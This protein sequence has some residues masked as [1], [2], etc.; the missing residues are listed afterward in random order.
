MRSLAER[1]AL[2]ER[3]RPPT[4]SDAPHVHGSLSD[5]EGRSGPAA[6]PLDVSRGHTYTKHVKALMRS[7]GR[8]G[9]GV[10]AAR[11]LNVH[12]GGSGRRHRRLKAK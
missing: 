4:L 2:G 7:R 5:I 9:R 10:F 6:A 11:D 12:R 1:Y 8:A 3:V